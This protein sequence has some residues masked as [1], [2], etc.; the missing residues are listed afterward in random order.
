[1]ASKIFGI[2]EWAFDEKAEK[3]RE[4]R[5]TQ[6]AYINKMLRDLKGRLASGDQTPSILGNILRQ[7]LL[8]DEE[9]LLAAYT[10]SMSSVFIMF[11]I[12]FIKSYNLIT[13]CH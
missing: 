13:T 3:A 2:E 7:N 10:G 1:M 6:Q 11:I 4:Y 8:N 12:I 9:T 5:M